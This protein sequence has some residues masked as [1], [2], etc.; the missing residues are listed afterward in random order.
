[1][2]K[3]LKQFTIGMVA[4]AIIYSIGI[5]ISGNTGIRQTLSII[6]VAILSIFYGA[7]L[8]EKPNNE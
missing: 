1:M 6:V 7:Y 3:D 4:A 8:M 2:K 5:L